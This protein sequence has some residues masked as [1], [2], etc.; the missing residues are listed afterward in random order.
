[1]PESWASPLA[2]RPVEMFKLSFALHPCGRPVA[3]L[4]PKSVIEF[5]YPHLL[6]HPFTTTN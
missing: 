1:M 6:N 2:M 3:A 5:V 4:R